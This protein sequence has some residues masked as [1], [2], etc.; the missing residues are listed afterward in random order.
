MDQ[1]TAFLQENWLVSVGVLVVIMIVIK[2]VKSVIKWLVIAGLAAAILIYGF[3]YTPEDIKEVG[4]KIVD[5]ID[6]SK[7]KAAAII[8]AN[9]T[10]ASFETTEDGFKV[11]TEKFK[12]E[13]KTGSNEAAFT[14]MGQTINIAL[15]E[16]L[17]SYIEN[18]KASNAGN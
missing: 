10:N 16:A 5:A 3:N 17:L 2:V 9:S 4:S 18:I 12:L 1:L 8:L 7:D 6:L 11:T 15:D 13:G 14:Y